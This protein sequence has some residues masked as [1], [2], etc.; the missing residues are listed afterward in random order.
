MMSSA[1]GSIIEDININPDQGLYATGTGCMRISFFTRL[2]SSSLLVIK[3]I[4]ESSSYY[5]RHL[6]VWFALALN[7][8]SL[9]NL[10]LCAE[11]AVNHR[12]G[13][14]SLFILVMRGRMH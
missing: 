13:A 6:K 4:S 12:G 3:S 8:L 5:F 2:N 11:L 14:L 7:I 10:V 9:N 1:S